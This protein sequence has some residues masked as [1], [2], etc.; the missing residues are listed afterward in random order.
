MGV[1]VVDSSVAVSVKLEPTGCRDG[2]A[3]EILAALPGNQGSSGLELQ[4]QV[5]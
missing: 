3:I 2:S 1:A 4:F 5:I